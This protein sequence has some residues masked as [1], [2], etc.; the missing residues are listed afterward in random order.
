M[1]GSAAPGNVAVPPLA[2]FGPRRVTDPPTQ[3]SPS[4]NV[5]PVGYRIG[6]VPWKKRHGAVVGI[7]L[8]TSANVSS[9]TIASPV[10]TS[11]APFGLTELAQPALPTPP[12]PH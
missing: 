1:C 10:D 7:P 4:P 11:N 2:V 12:F 6:L 3:R 5:V 9:D 8:A